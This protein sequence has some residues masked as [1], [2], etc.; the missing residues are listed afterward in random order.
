MV[1]VDPMW[2][3]SVV[4][5]DVTVARYTMSLA[6]LTTFSQALSGSSAVASFSWNFL[7]VRVDDVQDSCI[8]L[9]NY[10]AD[11]GRATVRGS[12]PAPVEDLAH[13]TSFGDI[14]IN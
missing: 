11:S 1:T 8:V 9:L 2:C 7:L 13:I 10:C 5:S 12:H 3:L 14:T 4:F 6:R